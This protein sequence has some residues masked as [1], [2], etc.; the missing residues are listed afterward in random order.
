MG[1]RLN[2]AR[3]TW[4]FKNNASLKLRYLDRDSD[5]DNYQGHSYTYI[6]FDELT[7]WPRPE[8]VCKLF[9]CLRSG[10]GVPCRFRATGNP[11]GPGHNWVK[12]QYI[13]PAPPYKV[14]IAEVNL[15]DGVIAR[16]R[17]VF[18]PSLLD[19]NLIL[20]KNDPNY[21]QRVAMSVS[22]NEA[23]LKAWRYGD[24]NIVAGGMFD[25]VWDPLIHII[26]PFSV[27]TT[28][29]VNRCFD[30][31][32]SQPFSVQWWAESDGSPTPEGK[33]YPPRTLFHV[34]EYYGW[35]GTANKGL[36][37][38]DAEVAREILRIEKELRGT[39]IPENATIRPGPAD[40]PD[41]KRNGRTIEDVMAA[42]GVRWVKPD[43]SSRVAGWKNMRA[44]LSAACKVPM[45]EPG[46]FIF[47]TCRNWIRTVPILPR[48]PRNPDDVLTTAED[49]AG[50][51]TRYRLQEVD[52]DLKIVRLLGF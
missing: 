24:W 48:D 26:D 41:D 43:K 38:D 3:R 17:R 45:E 29:R 25:D 10:A 11:G 31:G 15:P 34:A 19:H 52:R 9:A 32:S 4:V 51:C 5:A 36:C 37:M 50:D 49:H 16:S 2:V 13:D 6:A 14:H 47:D 30:W 23:L 8:P 7:H 1:A 33:K 12:S 20:Q 18:I 27:P 28:W 42:V 35:N 22:G 44:A 40:L 21:W 39:I 46:M